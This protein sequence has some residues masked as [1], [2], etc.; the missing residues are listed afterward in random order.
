MI[1]HIELVDRKTDIAIA[2]KYVDADMLNE[3]RRITTNS[4]Y[5]VRI[6]DE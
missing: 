5:Y 4:P 6:V 2:D 3:Y 1:M